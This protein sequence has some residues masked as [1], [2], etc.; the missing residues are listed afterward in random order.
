M[1]HFAAQ[2]DIP[3]TYRNDIRFLQQSEET[4]FR[5]LVSA[6]FKLLSGHT[7]LSSVDMLHTAL[8]PMAED[9]GVSTTQLSDSVRTLTLI[10][11][12]AVKRN[13]KHS[14]LQEDLQHLGMDSDKSQLISNLFR[15]QF[16]ALSRSAVSQTLTACPVVDMQ[17]R[18]G[19]TAAN[20]EISQ[21][22]STFLQ[23]SLTLDKSGQEEYVQMELSLEQFYE[24]LH[25]MEKAKASM[26]YFT[27]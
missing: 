18:F 25:E 21:V 14:F 26:S 11:Q 17:W 1:F 27:M 15:K 6:S 16:I 9:A 5:N 3:T 24:F 23:L 4:L 22:G 19:V 7:E 10:L 12:G 8:E 20:S 13:I 2:D